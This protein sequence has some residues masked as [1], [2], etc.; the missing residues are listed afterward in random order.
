MARKRR[1]GPKPHKFRNKLLLNQWMISLFGVDPL[2]EHKL[3]DRVVRPIHV[4][5]HPIQDPRME[6]LDESNT[7]RFFHNLVNHELF[8]EGRLGQMQL[9]RYEENIVRHTQAINEGREPKITWKYFQWLALLFAE[10]Y[11]DRYFNDMEGLLEDLNAFVARF[12]DRWTEY[13]DIPPYT[14]D[15]LNKVCIEMAT[16]SGKT[17]ITHVNLL[18]F[19]HYAS[20]AGRDQELSRAI[21]LTPNERLSRQ[22]H[23]EL[24]LSGISGARFE[25]GSHTLFT[26]EAKGLRRVDLLEITKLAEQ[27]GPQ[28]IA[29]HSLGDQNLL[30]VDEGHRGLSGGSTGKRAQEAEGAWFKYRNGL[31]SRGFTFEYSAT[32]EQA[33]AAAKNPE[34]E[35]AYAKTVL[36]DYSY[37]Y[38]YEDGFGKDYQILNL[39]ESFE[40]VEQM[41]LTACLLK[42][43]QQLRIYQEKHADFVAFNLEK[44]LWVFVGS[45][46]TGGAWKRDEKRVVSDVGKV[47]QFVAHFLHDTQTAQQRIEDLITKTGQD[48]G[49]LDADGGD[50][51]AGSFTYL[52]R[53]M[54]SGEMAEQMYGD[55]LRRVF[56]NPAGG[57]LLL[58]RV[59][60]DSGEVALKC[61]SADDPFGLINV[62]DAKGLCDHMARVASEQATPLDVTDTEFGETMFEDVSK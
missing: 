10:I 7:H 8:P 4:L 24:E 5:A 51:F 52:L 61:G 6:G 28:Q 14:E 59:R 62:G 50:I 54:N 37:R 17:L 48:T 27:R 34:I 53:Q 38:F 22:H 2:R 40:D 19:R 41:Y 35:D 29:A 1:S 12:N 9:L 33:V 36:F 15:D 25:G 58:S 26:A 56:R 32:F 57:T 42:F 20:R 21:L 11:L 60:G 23:R 46:V 47:L 45:S 13:R 3:N 16:G 18:Q 49:L 31:C 39:P 44:P 30:L 55:I 43:Y